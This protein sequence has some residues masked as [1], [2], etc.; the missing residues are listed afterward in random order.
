MKKPNF[1]K[2]STEVLEQYRDEIVE[3]LAEREKAEA[4]TEELENSIKELFAEKGLDV[5]DSFS[6]SS[7]LDPKPATTAA[8]RGPKKGSKRT[9]S[10][11][12]QNPNNPNETWSGL[13]RKPA[14]AKELEELGELESARIQ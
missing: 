5:P 3:I 2:L 11:R 12:Y 9:N 10:R 1:L 8:K 13:G 6:L 7:L 4:V 14:W